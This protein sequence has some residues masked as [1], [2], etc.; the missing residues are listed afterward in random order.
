MKEKHFWKEKANGKVLSV[1]CE[2]NFVPCEKGRR[3]RRKSWENL[4]KTNKFSVRCSV[5]EI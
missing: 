2:S 5:R 4:G 1:C 3:V